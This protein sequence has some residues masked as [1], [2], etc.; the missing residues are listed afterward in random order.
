MPLPFDLDLF[1]GLASLIFTLMILSYVI[2]DNFL[3]KLALY[4]FTGASA[5]YIASVAW[6]QVLLPKL[7][8]PLVSNPVQGLTLVF[9]PLIGILLI[10]MKLSPRLAG[11]GRLPMAFIVGAGAAVTIAGAL[12]GT[13]FPQVMGT[14]NAFDA[15]RG[16]LNV[17]IN[18]V[19]VLLGTVLTLIYFHFGAYAKPDGSPRRL[20]V[21]EWLAWL[22][23][24]FIGVT[25]GT[26]FAGVYS[27]ALTALIERITS[28]INLFGNL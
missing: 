26:I 13:L 20:R 2:G 17:M 7:V 15:S 28:I 6:W 5:G 21:I 8:L 3:F 9:V 4:I 27:S 14:I 24:F 1:A 16:F 22:G 10:V 12:S 25:L 18:G 19:A 11:A 23:R